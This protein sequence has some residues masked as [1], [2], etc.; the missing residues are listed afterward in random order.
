MIAVDLAI[1]RGGFRLEIAVRSDARRLGIYGPNGAGKSTLLEAISGLLRPERGTIE[2]D[3]AVLLDTAGGVSVGAEA[4]GIGVAFQDGRLLPDRTVAANVDFPL[5]CGR[6]S[7]ATRAE[8]IEALEL[9]PLLERRPG[10][11]SGGERQRVAIGRAVLAAERLLLLD[12]PLAAVERRLWP[13]V[14]ALVR[15]AVV[16][17]GV[18]VVHVSHDLG[19]L[20]DATEELAI[21]GRGGVVAVGR[22]AELVHDQAAGAMLLGGGWSNGL[23]AVIEHHDRAAGTSLVHLADG[24]PLVVPLVDAP[25]GRDVRLDIAPR[26]IAL[27]ARELSAISIRNQCPARVMRLSSHERMALVEVELSPGGP[28]LLVEVSRAAVDAMRLAPG[29]ELVALIKTQGIRAEL[30]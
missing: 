15:E 7:V 4:R 28:R 25:A 10:S 26:E 2:V 23:S 9:A 5:R 27:A 13:A 21:L 3:G 18:P 17:R 30:A 1:A 20:R 11:L 19:E 22:S 24:T 6:R 8:V 29:T 12:E 14:I 16:A